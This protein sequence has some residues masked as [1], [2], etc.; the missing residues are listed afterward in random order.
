MARYGWDYGTTWNRG[1]W[2]RGDYDRDYGGYT[3]GGYSG[4]GPWGRGTYGDR[5]FGGGYGGDYSTGWGRYPGGGY[6]GGG[7]Y[8][9][10]ETFQGWGGPWP[11]SRVWYAARLRGSRLGRSHARGLEP[12]AAGGAPHP[13]RRLRP[14]VV[15]GIF[16]EHL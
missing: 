6:Y 14:R 2:D 10:G 12:Y 13:R 11:R 4:G 9:R 5:Y 1:P 16:D 15:E 8:G 3:G 7:T